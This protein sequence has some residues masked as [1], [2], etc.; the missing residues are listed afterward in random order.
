[1]YPKV[2]SLRCEYKVY[3]MLGAS[4]ATDSGLELWF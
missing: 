1:M 2:L 3:E 4:V